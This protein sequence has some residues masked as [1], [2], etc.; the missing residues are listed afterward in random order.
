MSF[1]ALFQAAV[2]KREILPPSRYPDISR[3][4]ALLLA[5]TVSSATVIET[6]LSLGM[7]DLAEV[8]IFDVYHG[9]HL[10]AGHKSIAIRVRYH[11]HERTLTDEEVNKMHQKVVNTL[12]V[13]L[14]ATIR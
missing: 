5:E 11:S 2:E 10:P 1:D 3:D 7:R 6:V 13:K 4:V 12:T 8:G 14:G 9:E